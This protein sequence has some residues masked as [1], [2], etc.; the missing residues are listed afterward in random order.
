MSFWVKQGGIGCVR[1]EKF[2]CIFF[3]PKVARTALGQVCFDVPSKIVTPK[4]QTNMSF[5][6]MGVDWVRSCENSTARFFVQKW[7][8]G[9]S[10][11]SFAPLFYRNRN[12]KTQE[13]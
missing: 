3:V 11:E 7:L 13:S 8:N 6:E 12:P 1:C 4:T 5:G 2:N 9:P 10:R